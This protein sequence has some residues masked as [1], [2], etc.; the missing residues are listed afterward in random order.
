[1]PAVRQQGGLGVN[2]SF[3]LSDVMPSVESIGD[4]I[5][6]SNSTPAHEISVNNLKSNDSFEF[7]FLFI[8]PVG[9]N[10]PQS[11]DEFTLC[12]KLYSSNVELN[13]AGAVAE[14]P[15]VKMTRHLKNKWNDRYDALDIS[16]GR[17]ATE[18]LTL[19]ED[20]RAAAIDNGPPEQFLRL[21]TTR[22]ARGEV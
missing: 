10:G 12:N 8:K 3:S 21:F 15:W 1:M 7:K 18:I 5:T 9:K 17:W 19:H 22:H 2:A 13:R 4:F 20:S 11:K 14:E 16:W 6:V